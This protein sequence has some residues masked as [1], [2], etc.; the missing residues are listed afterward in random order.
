M[1]DDKRDSPRPFDVRTVEYLIKLMTEHDLSEVELRE[2]DQRIRVRKGAANPP[3]RPCSRRPRSAV[4]APNP[5]HAP[6]A[7]AQTQTPTSAPARNLPR[8]Q[9]ADGRDVLLEAQA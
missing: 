4:S 8:D 7:A 3:P 2:G 9:V 6:A 5:G 1:A